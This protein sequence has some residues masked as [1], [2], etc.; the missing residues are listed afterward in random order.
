MLPESQNDQK[1]QTGNKKIQKPKNENIGL[2]Y[3]NTEKKR[4]FHFLSFWWCIISGK[5]NNI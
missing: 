1:K 5:V 4:N 3:L 2:T